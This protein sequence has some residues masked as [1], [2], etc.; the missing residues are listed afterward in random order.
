MTLCRTKVIVFHGQLK[1]HEYVKKCVQTHTQNYLCFFQWGEF[2]DVH[3]RVSDRW[4]LI[5]FLS[6]SFHH[7]LSVTRQPHFFIEVI[8]VVAAAV[9]LNTSVRKLILL[10]RKALHAKRSVPYLSWTVAN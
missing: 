9:F 2:Q 5:H 3:K 6:I 8:L 7:T 1:L 4:S 10:E